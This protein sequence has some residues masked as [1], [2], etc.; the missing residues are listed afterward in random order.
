MHAAV[1]LS[2][3]WV[4]VGISAAA[5][6]DRGI[7]PMAMK[8]ILFLLWLMER[9]QQL[10]IFFFFFGKSPWEDANGLFVSSGIYRDTQ[11]ELTIVAGAQTDVTL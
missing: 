8:G 6:K 9:E 4:H 5:S 2:R 11:Q 10:L 3:P 7:A 1:P